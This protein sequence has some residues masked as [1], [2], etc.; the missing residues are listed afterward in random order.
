[1]IVNKIGR[2]FDVFDLGLKL[3]L[4]VHFEWSQNSFSFIYTIDTVAAFCHWMFAEL[5]SQHKAGINHFN[6][7]PALRLM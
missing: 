4:P 2:V 3:K 7:H 5:F 1:M 6:N